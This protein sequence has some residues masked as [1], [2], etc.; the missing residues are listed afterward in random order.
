MLQKNNI[1]RTLNTLQMLFQTKRYSL[2][3]K[4]NCS[5]ARRKYQ[6]NQFKGEIKN[7]KI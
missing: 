3:A 1:C 4:F 2:L 5:I 6:V 7:D